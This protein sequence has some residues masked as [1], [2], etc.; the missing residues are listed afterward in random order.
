MTAKS[1]TTF[2]SDQAVA[3][4]D[5]TTGN[6]SALDLR[7]QV[8]D[9]ADS[10]SFPEDFG[11]G[12]NL[13]MTAAERAKL[14][15][16]TATQG[17]DLDA[18]EA[19]VTALD[20]AFV[21]KG[22]WD[23]SAGTFPGAGAALAG[24][25]WRVSVGGTVDSVVFVAGDEVRAIVD[26]ASTTV[27][28]ANW[29]KT[30]NTD[31]VA[32]VAGLTGTITGAGLKTA[33]GQHVTADYADASVTLAKMANLAGF[34]IPA[35]AA[36]G[37]GVMAALTAGVDGVLRRSGSGDLA[38][39]ALVTNNLGNNI[40]TNAKAAQMAQNTIKGRV[41]AGTGNPEDLT[42]TQATTLLDVFTSAAKGL[43][44]ASGGGSTNFLRA[45]GT[46]AVPAGGGG[47]VSAT[48]F[49]NGTGSTLTK[50]APV[51]L[52]AYNVGSTTP[53]M[54]A[55]D[56]NAGGFM[57]CI[58]ILGADCLNAASAAPIT[59]GG[60]II[61]LDTSSY[62]LNQVLY[63]SDTAGTLTGT[64]P[65]TGKIQ[66]VAFVSRV[67]A[68]LGEIIVFIAPAGDLFIENFTVAVSDEATALTT[69][70]AKLTF[71]MPYDFT[72]TAI[73]ASVNTA[74]TGST[75][76]VD[77]NENGA[78]TLST[79]L[80]IDDSEKTSTTAAVA[81]VISDSALADDA[82][83][84]IDIDQVGSTIAG[85]GLKVTFYGYRP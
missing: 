30:D 14:A 48:S 27:F 29:F 43:A 66:P 37:S 54:A 24:E 56:A 16:L 74:P 58:G 84:T 36:T 64:R 4:A 60:E 72:L 55:A 39:G 12:D 22:T 83:I 61:G 68:T 82:E 46:W 38:F 41:T 62:S 73:R 32:S 69:G 47:G 71:R 67:D 35:R 65:A 26:S 44:P 33:L 5:N 59:T 70:T 50:G 45:D 53:G 7:T 25:S 76:I 3:F 10:A 34:S 85:K 9:L 81:A 17:V 42:G 13:L 77:V 40:V 57:P 79:K 8:D 51:C 28:A 1:R 23:A 2:K 49:F 20:Q 18:V 31:A 19:R 6:I 52:A 80:S 11:A 21:D 63:V 75:I 78:T 15:F